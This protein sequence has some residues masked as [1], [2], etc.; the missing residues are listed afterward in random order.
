[1]P[2]IL[3]QQSPCSGIQLL[4]SAPITT[5]VRRPGQ[6]AQLSNG[7]Q[8]CTAVCL[9]CVDRP[10]MVYQNEELQFKA[11]QDFPA[12]PDDAVCPV[13]AISWDMQNSRPKI[14]AGICI[15][16]GL[17]AA[18]CPVSAI[19]FTDR[20]QV[21]E[22]TEGLLRFPDTPEHRNLQRWQLAGLQT[23]SVTGRWFDS[24]DQQIQQLYRTISASRYDPQFPNR[25]V[26]NCLL[27]LGYDCVVRRRGDVN[28]R[29]DALFSCYGQTG[30]AE[31]EFHQDALEP[32]RA[33]LDDIAVLHARYGIDKQ[34]ILPLIVHFELPNTRTGHWQVVEDIVSVLDIR[35]HTITLGALLLLL[36]HGKHPDLR[37]DTCFLRQTRHSLREFLEENGVITAL[38]AGCFSML[39]PEK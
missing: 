4:D 17:C 10:C 35:I 9:G 21:S 32:P 11:V 1:M 34:A 31:I 3:P 18:R 23:A 5:I 36:W 2:I 28:L 29:M 13:G 14:A 38:S 20:F 22:Q 27:G 15:A 24:C 7:T 30:V 39:E 19:Y 16:C 12:S 33:I 25:L 26:R 6:P 8:E 37:S